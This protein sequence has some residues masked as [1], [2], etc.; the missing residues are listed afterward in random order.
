MSGASE[1]GGSD[2]EHAVVYGGFNIKDLLQVEADLKNYAPGSGIATPLERRAMIN[3]LKFLQVETVLHFEREYDQL[4]YERNKDGGLECVRGISPARKKDMLQP[5]KLKRQ[6]CDLAEKLRFYLAAARVAKQFLDE[7]VQNVVGGLE[8]CEIQF[9]DVKSLES[10]E[11]KTVN[12]CSGDVRKVADMARLSVVCKK[13]EDL[14]QAYLGITRTL[15]P[16]DIFRVTNGFISDWMPSGYRDVKLNAVVNGHLCEIQL[17]LRE[18]YNLKRHQHVVY[19]WA[20]DL[21]VTKA[22]VADQ[23]FENLS[24]DVMDEMI[25]LSEGNW[26]ETGFLLPRLQLSA[27]RYAHAEDGHRKALSEAERTVRGLK[28]NAT[29]EW[30]WVFRQEIQA[31]A[32]LGDCLE[33][34]GKYDE[35]EPLYTR[36]I[37]DGEETL[38]EGHPEIAVWMNDKAIV[39][40]NQGKYEEAERLFKRAKD[41]NEK[42]FGEEHPEVATVLDNWAS[43]LAE[44]K[45]NYAEAAPL[46][47]RS[48]DIREKV[49]GPDHP[50]V[51]Q[52]LNNRAALLQ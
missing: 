21:N 47:E 48:Q 43:F 14:K 10:T 37:V 35:A 50:D 28:D 5:Q 22:M 25:R 11:R 40:Q 49:L 9:A 27:G 24:R 7:L 29:K 1:G 30:K 41:I 19:E 46:Y 8:G 38:G 45:G 16:R 15:K 51:A 23:L 20:R 52:S 39:L 36:A 26:H 3:L 2:A 33:R 18:F 4:R 12:F 17:H 31:A 44:S 6:K 13:P 34:Q 42:N 32:D